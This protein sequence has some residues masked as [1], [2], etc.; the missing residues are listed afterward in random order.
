MKPNNMLHYVNLE[1]NHPPVLLKNIPEGVNKRLSEISSDEDEF[2]KAAPQYQ[3]ALDDTGYSFKLH[4]ERK[5]T[6]TR[7]KKARKRNV[8][9]YNPPYDKNV[10]TNVGRQFLK[11]IDKCFP[12]G[13]KLHKIFDR[14]TV[15]IS[16]SCM[17]NIAAIIESNNKEKLREDEHN[18]MQKMCNCPPR[19][20][21]PLDGECL[22]ENIVYQATIISQDCRKETYVGL[23]AASFKHSKT[24]FEKNCF[25]AWASTLNM[26]LIN[27][28]DMVCLSPV[29]YGV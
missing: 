26:G 9:L 1:S 19:S 7:K 29:G 28:V 27:K 15:K 21:C 17:P 25:S 14:N 24:S 10:K 3:K 11:I 23:T 13:N 6:G 2:T 4:Y 16:Y 12:P 20:E 5:Q 8:I 22:A 18:A